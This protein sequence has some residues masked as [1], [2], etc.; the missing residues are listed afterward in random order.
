VVDSSRDRTHHL[1][2]YTGGLEGLRIRGASLLSQRIAGILTL[3]ARLI[4]LF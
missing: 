4:I 3:S 1:L 2:A